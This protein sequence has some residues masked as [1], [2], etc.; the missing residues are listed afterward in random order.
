MPSPPPR[1]ARVVDDLHRRCAHWSSS[2]SDADAQWHF[3]TSV[4]DHVLGA[5]RV[6]YVCGCG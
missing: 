2:S 4:M 5:V 3:L 6:L 1:Q